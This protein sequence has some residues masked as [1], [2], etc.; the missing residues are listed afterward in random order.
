MKQSDMFRMHNGTGLRNMSLNGKAGT[1]GD[2]NNNLTRR[3]NGGS[4]VSLDPAN[5]PSDT[6]AWITN[7]SPYVQNV[8]T[9]GTG[10][11]G[12]KD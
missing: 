7:K 1:L 3:P 2:T 5:G 6:Y 12:M 9:F 10:C 8:S 4:Y 11:I